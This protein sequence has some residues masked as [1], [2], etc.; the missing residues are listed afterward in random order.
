MIHLFSNAEALAQAA[1]T[2]FARASSASISARGRFTVALSGGST[3]KRLHAL[4]A[5]PPLR[6]QVAWDR[7]HLLFGDER[8]VPPSD[9]QSNERMARE[10]LVSRVP[11]PEA[12]VHGMYA[13][14]GPDAAASAYEDLVRSL[15]GDELAIDLTLLGLGP[16]GHTAS[17]F[18]GRPSV[19]ETD[20]LVIAAKA[21]AGVEDRITMTVPLLNRSREILFLAAGADKADAVRRALDA[22]ENWDETPSQA[23]ARHAPNVVWF[24]DEAANAAR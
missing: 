24:L 18:P 9:E 6:D 19:H 11:I 3:P 15:L 7:V 16:D 22:P 17:L 20:R 5:S 2:E 10:T 8:Y 4:L 13:P 12:N 21:N 14:G 23:V 1:A